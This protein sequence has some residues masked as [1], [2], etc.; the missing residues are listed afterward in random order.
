LIGILN[1]MDNRI[2]N[3]ETDPLIAA[4]FSARD[5]SGKEQNKKALLSEFGLDPSRSDRPVLAMISRIDVQKGFDLVVTILDYLL[6]QDLSFVLLGSGNRETEAYLRSV[7]ERYADK[8]GIRFGFND[9]LAHLTEAGADI[10]LMPSKYEPC[11][12]NQM[13]SL[14]YGTVPIV[15]S[16]GG[17]ADTVREFNPATGAG[18]GFCFSKYDPEE[19]KAA[20]GRALALWPQRDQWRRLMINGMSQDFSW[21]ES[22]RKYEEAYRRVVAFRHAP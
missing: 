1:G 7:V 18:T 5:L 14:R 2:W 15:R 9:R 12:L 8:S 16:T 22:A 20:V 13:Y 11:G 21:K 6:A 4:S 19:F 17:L 10:F 3:P